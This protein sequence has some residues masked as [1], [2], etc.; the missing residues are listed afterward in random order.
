MRR[1]VII[2]LCISLLRKFAAKIMPHQ[3]RICPTMAAVEKPSNTPIVKCVA[4]VLY[5]QNLLV[6]HV[7]DSNTKPLIRSVVAPIFFEI[8]GTSCC[9][10]RNYDQAKKDVVIIR[11]TLS[12]MQRSPN[13]Y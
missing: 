10:K 3:S 6:L 13:C 1:L 2:A 9:G 4:L 11:W 7:V 8:T 12:L 5:F